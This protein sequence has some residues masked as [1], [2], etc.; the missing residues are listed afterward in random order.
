MSARPGGDRL[1]VLGAGLYQLAGIGRAVEL[2]CEVVTVDN[3]PSNPGHRLSSH[4][5]DLSTTDVA[6]VV[7]VA[8]ELDID[9]IVTFSSDVATLSVASVCDAMGLPGPTADAVSRTTDKARFRAFQ[10]EHGLAGPRHLEVA[11]PLD[12]DVAELDGWAWPVIVKP[13][14]S[15]GSR[16]VTSVDDPARLAEAVRAAL[17]FSRGGRVVVEEFVG[18]LEVGGDLFLSDSRPLGGM[19][20]NKHRDGFVVVGHSVPSTLPEPVQEHVLSAVA[21]TC[22]RVGIRGGPVNFDVMV[23]LDV[24]PATVVILELSP[25]TGGNGIPE[26]IDHAVGFDLYEATIRHALGHPPKAR[27]DAT[28]RPCGSAVFGSP[29][30]GTLVSFDR[31]ATLGG[32]DRPVLSLYAKQQ[33]GDPVASFDHGGSSMGYVVFG[34]RSEQ[35]YLAAAAGLPDLLDITVRPE[36]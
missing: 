7:R 14:D 11:D 17:E 20:T 19:I 35:D 9:G 29:R 4:S 12:V 16:G 2:G 21:D 36:S 10:A 31:P 23:D 3:V 18:G 15:S 22:R 30:A 5:V 25:R 8:K 13:V 32:P 24:E 28:R 33:P 6:G 27:G 34:C 1:M 26:L